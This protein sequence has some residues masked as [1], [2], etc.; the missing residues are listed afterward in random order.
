LPLEVGHFPANNSAFIRHYVANQLI[1]WSKRDIHFQEALKMNRTIKNYLSTAVAIAPL[2]FLA[3]RAMGQYVQTNLVSNTSTIPAAIVDPNLINPWG[4]VATATSP[5]W[6]SDNN[7]GLAT[8]Y[9]GSGTPQSLVV[10]IPGPNGSPSGFL[11]APTGIVANTTTGFQVSAGKSAHF[12]FDTEDGTISAWNSGTNAVLEVDNSTT[13]PGAVYKGLAIDPTSETLYATNFRAATV[14]AYGPTFAPVT[15][16]GS[17]T[18]PNL[19]AG[20]APFGI[21]N[22]GGDLFVTYAVQDADKHDDTAGP[23][24]GLVAEFDLSGNYIKTI[25]SGGTLNSPWGLALAPSDFGPLSGDLLVGDFGDGRIN[26]YNLGTDAFVGQLSD[27]SG[28]PLT[29]DG[30][31]G[32]DFGNGASAG[33]ADVLYFTSG[34]DGEANGLFGDISVPEPASIS[35]LGIGTLGLLRRTRHSN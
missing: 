24:N 23:G 17:F 19:P 6:V 34:P 1:G 9:N 22:I 30:L 2:A 15:L 18:V 4:I 21:Q 12:I 32:L 26:A 29:I 33:P 25:A 20:Y 27:G 7:A 10:T 16:P 28:T 35:L 5:F 13:G 3:H 11:A 8:L 14:E 31:W